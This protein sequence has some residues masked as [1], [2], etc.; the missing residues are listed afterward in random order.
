MNFD[1]FCSFSSN[2]GIVLYLMHLK[3]ALEV[4]NMCDKNNV[5]FLCLLNTITCFEYFS[6]ELI[7]FTGL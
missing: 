6:T 7:S 5:A 2:L 1:E 4:L 3:S